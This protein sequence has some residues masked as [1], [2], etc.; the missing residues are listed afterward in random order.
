MNI[1]HQAIIFILVGGLNTLFG[2]SLYAFFIYIGLRYP[3]AILFSTLLGI[4]F[5]YRSI[6]KFVFNYSNH[7]L[8]F[9]FIGVYLIIYL[10][11]LFL[12]QIVHSLV[13]NLYFAGFIALPPSATLAFILNK[14]FVF[15]KKYETN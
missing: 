13:V 8:F 7:D 9:K 3:L 6:G 2:Y 4:L 11:N 14:H 5:N 12:I 15:R 10:F 1:K